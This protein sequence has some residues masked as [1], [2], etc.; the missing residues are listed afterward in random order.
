MENYPVLPIVL[1]VKYLTKGG[2]SEIDAFEL[3]VFWQHWHFRICHDCTNALNKS[4]IG[5]T[6]LRK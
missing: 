6:S 1:L 4:I 3:E 2:R 5:R